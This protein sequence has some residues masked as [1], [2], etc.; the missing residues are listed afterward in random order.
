M[1]IPFKIYPLENNS[2]YSTL[3]DLVREYMYCPNC[4]TNTVDINHKVTLLSSIG[5]DVDDIVFVCK[6][7]SKRVDPIT[8]DKMRDEKIK[9]INI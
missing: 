6:C 5:I 3:N 8:L 2:I 4:L 9:R 1:R 7:C